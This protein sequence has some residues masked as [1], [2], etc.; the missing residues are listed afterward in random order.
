[1]SDLGDGEGRVANISAALLTGGASS[2]MGRDKASLT[3][4]GVPLAVRAARLLARFFSDV[5]IVGGEATADVPGRFVPDS[6]PDAPR[7]ALRGIV[8]AL[9]HAKADRVLVLATD[10][11]FV[12]PDLILG[13]T[14]WPEHDVVLPRRDGRPD[15][16][17]GIYRRS[18]LGV[19]SANLAAGELALRSVF[20]AVDTDYLEGADLEA[21][22]PDG[23][24]LTNLNLPEDLERA[25]ALLRGEQ[26]R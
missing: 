9:E 16:L 26:P 21:L 1:M 2:R 12:T 10:M 6:H 20:E 15:P 19:A 5:M 24:A 17:C 8:T 14:A 23:S 7:C 25:E 22:D 13:L 4:S 11:P 3:L 18:I